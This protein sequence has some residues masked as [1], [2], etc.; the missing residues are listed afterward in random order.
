MSRDSRVPEHLDTKYIVDK[1][2]PPENH[3]TAIF[4]KWRPFGRSNNRRVVEPIPSII[5]N[6]RDPVSLGEVDGMFH[7]PFARRRLRETKPRSSRRGR[8]QTR[9][10]ISESGREV[11]VRWSD[12]RTGENPRSGTRETLWS[13][14]RSVSTVN[15]KTP[16]KVSKVCTS[17]A[18][19]SWG[20][21]MDRVRV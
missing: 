10:K 21:Q 12:L 15:C 2:S 3:G 8:E 5:R 17:A 18:V 6:S 11:R 9:P 1:M 19:M 16:Q 7:P 20:W 4:V 13:C 14:H